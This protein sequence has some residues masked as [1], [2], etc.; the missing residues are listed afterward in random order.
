MFGQ[1]KKMNYFGYCY[2][3]CFNMVHILEINSKWADCFFFFLLFLVLCSSVESI[4]NEDNFYLRFIMV[5]VLFFCQNSSAPLF[6]I[7]IHIYRL[8]RFFFFFVLQYV[9][10]LAHSLCFQA[11][12]REMISDESDGTWKSSI[13]CSKCWSE[14]QNKKKRKMS[15]NL[16]CIESV[17]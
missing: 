4:F 11:R 1:I 16:L 15:R 2:F 9:Q 8:H 7:N 14:L 13:N 10:N 3:F 6:C 5:W 12:V 17:L